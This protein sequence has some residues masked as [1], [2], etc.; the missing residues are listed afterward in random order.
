MVNVSIFIEGGILP[1]DK[2]NV[3]TIDNS[4]KLREGFYIILSQIISPTEFNITIKQGSSNKQTI[5]FFKK[6]FQKGQNFLLLIDLDGSKHEKANKFTEFDLIDYSDSVFF[7]VQEMEAWIIS[8]IDKI[9]K[10]YYGKFIRKKNEVALSEH[11]KIN[12]IHPEDITKPSIVLKEILGQYFRTKDNKKKKYGKLKDGADLLSI[13]DANDLQK[14]F[15][16]FDALIES[17]K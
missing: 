2:V 13:L 16:D 10:Y 1:N 4:E 6:K 17:I 8:Q 11:V 7:M 14:T 15:S 9:D 12:N 3:Q 5:M